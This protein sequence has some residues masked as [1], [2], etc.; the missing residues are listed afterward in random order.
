[1]VPLVA[2]YRTASKQLHPTP[3]T[4]FESLT[5]EELQRSVWERLQQSQSASTEAEDSEDS[6]GPGQELLFSQIQQGWREKGTPKCWSQLG[7]LLESLTDECQRSQKEE[8]WIFGLYKPRPDAKTCA[9][10]VRDVFLQGQ[11][12]VQT[13]EMP[14][15]KLASLDLP[16][17]TV[18][19]MQALMYLQSWFV[20]LARTKNFALLWAGF[21]DGDRTN[22]TTTSALFQFANETDH[23]T[24]HPDSI[25]G[26][27]IEESQDLNACYEDAS[28][29]QMLQNMWTFSSMSFVSNMRAKA[30]GTV[31]AVVNKGLTGE[32]NLSESVLSQYEMPTLG[33]TAWGLGGWSPHIIILDMRG[34]C[35]DTSPSLRAQLAAHLH[36]WS[37]LRAEKGKDETKA[38]M[39]RSRAS[40]DCV[41]CPPDACNLDAAL[42][43]HIQHMVEAKKTQDDLNEKLFEAVGSTGRMRSEAAEIAID[44]EMLNTAISAAFPSGQ[45]QWGSILKEATQIDKTLRKRRH[46]LVGSKLRRAFALGERQRDVESLLHRKADPQTMELDGRT[47]LHYAAVN[48]YLQILDILL[49]NK[50]DL[51]A[52]DRGGNTALLCAALNGHVEVVESL[53]KN[54]A[55]P[56]AMD[57]FGRTPLH[58][59]AWHCLLE[60]VES[61]L[62]NKADPNAKDKEGAT[63]LNEAA[64]Q[65]HLEVV[66]SLLKNKADPNAMD[67]FGQ[68]PLYHAARQGLPEVVESLLKNRADPNA[69]DHFGRTPLHLAAK[70]GHLDVVKSLLKNMADRNAMDEDGSTPL[71]LAANE[72]HLEVVESLLENKADPNAKDKE[73]ATPLHYAAWQG[74]LEVVESLL[75]NK[76]DPN[77]MDKGGRKEGATPLHYAATQGHLEVVE[78]LLKNK[79][80]RNAMD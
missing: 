31:V 67:K 55:D 18:R 77:A 52:A 32:R 36:S 33:I 72:G 61:L 9:E 35:H 51:N 73:G 21:W 2:T 12:L 54:K 22:R 74:H 13:M 23:D 80:D 40:W 16:N 48:G 47:P 30:Q 37:G 41:D 56:N 42:A 66:E 27:L 15:S 53:L 38:F 5:P 59:A 26:R 24:V 71:H 8:H 17:N 39:K 64:R 58:Y 69:M 49:Q 45:R 44:Q 34:T 6:P 75:K 7:R 63:P 78:S 70:E 62:E 14:R 43:Q 79:A 3:W 11:R 76:A 57:Q 29:N 19:E 10:S 20:P 1:M 60:V 68:T 65:G 25:M 50:A 4:D 46:H 28:T